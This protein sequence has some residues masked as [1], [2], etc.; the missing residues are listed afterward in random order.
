MHLFFINLLAEAE[1]AEQARAHDPVKLLIAISV[2]LLAVVVAVVEVVG[3]VVVVAA[4]EGEWPLFS[5]CVLWVLAV[6]FSAAA[7]RRRARRG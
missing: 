4:V 6:C 1:Q 7:R 5:V 3:V 2:W